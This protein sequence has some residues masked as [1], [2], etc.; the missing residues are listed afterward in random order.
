MQSCAGN[1][2]LSAFNRTSL[3]E[4]G[5]RCCVDRQTKPKLASDKWG[6]RHTPVD[7]CDDFTSCE[8]SQG[9]SQPLC[10]DLLDAE[11]DPSDGQLEVLTLSRPDVVEFLQGRGL[12][13]QRFCNLHDSLQSLCARLLR[14][15]CSDIYVIGHGPSHGRSQTVPTAT[16]RCRAS[17]RLPPLDWVTQLQTFLASGLASFKAAMPTQKVLAA[18]LCLLLHGSLKPHMTASE[19]SAEA[20]PV[21]NRA[22]SH[23]AGIVVTRTIA[24]GWQ[25]CVPGSSSAFRVQA[26]KLSSET[27]SLSHVV[28]LLEVQ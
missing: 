23:G 7:R 17:S 11:Q 1:S 5:C 14:A 24:S 6:S 12:S 16:S 21:I 26:A 4:P 15:G 25:A 18:W 22:T 2:L 13:T 20:G 9:T 28:V 27:Q 3:S 8:M 10:E 19:L